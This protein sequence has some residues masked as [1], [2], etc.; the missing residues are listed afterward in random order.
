MDKPY[1]ILFFILGLSAHTQT[2]T[3]KDLKL[4]ESNNQA[5]SYLESK[6]SKKNKLITF[7]EEKHNTTLAKA[8]FKLSKGRTK[9]EENEFNKIYYKVVEKN[10]TK[11]Y[12]ISTIYF[13]GHKI[14]K[15]D[16][17]TLR[18]EII[19]KYKNGLPFSNLV[20]K[21][22]MGKNV[23][24]GGDIGWFAKGEIAKEFDQEI[25]T[26]THEIGD[27]FTIDI[28]L[29]KKYYVVVKTHDPK[30]INEIKVLKIVESK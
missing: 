1:L 7:N 14:D 8:L 19:K 16:I 4:I 20:K 23:D 5:L 15:E 21:Y 18:Q 11:H 30:E 12:R 9:V 2:S 22:S 29:E 13:D 6:S 27:I 10:K 26:N 25:I 28:P 24:K 3:K 17:N